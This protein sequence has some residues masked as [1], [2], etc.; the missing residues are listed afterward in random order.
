[1]FCCTS[2]RQYIHNKAPR[3]WSITCN[4]R[5]CGKITI[6]RVRVCVLH[7]KPFFLPV[8]IQHNQCPWRF[9]HLRSDTCSGVTKLRHRDITLPRTG[10]LVCS[11]HSSGQCNIMSS[12]Y[13]YSKHDKHILWNGETK[14]NN[15][16]ENKNKEDKSKEKKKNNESKNK[17][18]QSVV[19]PPRRRGGQHLKKNELGK[20]SFW[21]LLMYVLQLHNMGPRKTWIT[22]NHR[23]CSTRKITIKC[24]RG[25][26]TLNKTVVETVADTFSSRFR[27]RPDTLLYLR[28]R[29]W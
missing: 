24:A 10:Y 16:R 11:M 1:M 18:K 19:P 27:P 14:G 6:N 23:N 3:K 15:H 4:R 9:F 13:R 12:Y 22:C 5:I 21:Y 26:L 28:Q 7:I 25:V 8:D 20:Y 29:T 2:C 17:M